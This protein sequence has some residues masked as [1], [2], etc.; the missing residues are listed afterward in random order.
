[1]QISTFE[2]TVDNGVIKLLHNLHLP[3]K[4]KVY[5]IVPDLEPKAV[6]YIYSPRLK[7]PEQIVDFQ[8]EMI[9]ITSDAQL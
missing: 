7:H 2:G 5:V 3:D 9:E 8:K 1:M 6:S 4:T